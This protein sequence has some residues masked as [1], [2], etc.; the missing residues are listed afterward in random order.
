MTGRGQ[1]EVERLT[2]ALEAIA[3][4]CDY[5]VDERGRPIL[6]QQSPKERFAYETA[7]EA[8][9]WDPYEMRGL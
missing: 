2:A 4:R 6:T 5:A 9:G 8:L 1:S 3:R 7:C